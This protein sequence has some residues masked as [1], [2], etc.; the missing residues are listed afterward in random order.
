[1]PFCSKCGNRVGDADVYCGRCGTAQPVAPGA[2]PPPPPPPKPGPP[3][4][5]AHLNPRTAAILCYIPGLGW[6]AAIVVLASTR[7]RI[8]RA[9]R[10]HA[11][12]GL[13]LFVAWL[14]A[15][16]V[17]KPMTSFM[18]PH[19]NLGSLVQVVVLVMSIFMI[20]K[21]AH[22]ETYSLPLFGELAQ[23]SIAEN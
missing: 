1:M 2:M 16:W 18:I 4:P 14:M 23:R 15:D 10:F 21:V 19:F 12:Q 9:L 3:D 20:V 11:F 8:D 5:L 13:Y 17:F 6:I 7:F 22:N